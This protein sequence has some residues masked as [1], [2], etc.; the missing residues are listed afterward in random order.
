MD[1]RSTRAIS[2]LSRLRCLLT[3]LK[4]LKREEKL[5]PSLCF[6]P[7]TQRIVYS[8]PK[9]LNV[10]SVPV[11]ESG[12][13]KREF[14][15]HS[16]EVILTFVGVPNFSKSSVWL[17]LVDPVE[18]WVL[19]GDGD[20]V[21]N[22]RNPSTSENG[23]SDSWMKAIDQ[24]FG[25]D[26]LLKS[27][28]LEGN[29]VDMKRIQAVP[30][31]WT[32]ESD[33]E[34]T[35]FLCT[36]D[37]IHNIGGTSKLGEHFEKV[38][39]SSSQ[40]SCKNLIDNDETTYW[41]SNGS[42]GQHYIRLHIKSGIMLEQL[43][44]LVDLE[45]DSYLPRSV[46]VKGIDRTDKKHE[47][48]RKMFSEEDYLTGELK[49]LTTPLTIQYPKI[50]IYIKS[51]HSGGIDTRIHGLVSV[52]TSQGSIIDGLHE[53]I[54][55]EESLVHYPTLQS[56]KTQDLAIRSF[57]LH[58]LVTLLNDNLLFLLPQWEHSTFVRESIS[59]IKLLLPL[60]PNRQQII[61]NALFSTSCKLSGSAPTLSINRFSAAEH[62]E[63][64]SKDPTGRSTVFGQIYKG[65]QSKIQ[66]GKFHLRWAGRESQ[67][68][69]CKFSKEH[70]IDQGGGFRDSLTDVAEELCPPSPD[71]KMPLPFFIHS[72][73]QDQDSSN[74]Y[75][76]AYIPNPSC[77]EFQMYEF[78][79]MLMGG[80]YR[81]N[82][83]LVLALSKYFWKQLVGEPVTWDD[84]SSV[85][86]AEVKF[87]NSLESM[88]KDA[89]EAAFANILTYTT[90]LSSGDVVP[91]IS[92][93]DKQFVQYED[94]LRYCQLVR[95]KRMSESSKQLEAIMTGFAKCVPKEI[96]V[97]H[98]WREI[99]RKICGNPEVT[100]E[101]LKLH[102]IYESDLSATDARVTTMWRAL[103]KF[104]NDERGQFLRFITGRRRLPCSIFIQVQRQTNSLPRAA[105]C[106][107]SLYLPEYT[108]VDMAYN[109]LLYAAYSCIAIDTDG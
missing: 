28:K 99:E 92:G 75:R 18:G 90:L 27:A 13:K 108:S 10:Y 40:D 55:T 93:G 45:D 25:L 72:P 16:K 79:G 94:R 96:L 50:E 19:I 80:A 51:C 1:D 104:T 44:L 47:V 49:L 69:E 74:V 86:S 84:F 105:T 63:D 88:T 91:L 23:C 11:Q 39:A 58:R 12:K 61:S 36:C 20:S 66:N 65:L 8:G 31:G 29:E 7:K 5:H 26:T 100:V 106:S 107:N 95:A 54:F 82:E 56:V 70:I 87:I 37:A 35:K 32:Y 109:K 71:V 3:S 34:L 77:T 21:G 24:S 64:P 38:E 57:V 67:W 68:W 41:E 2:R 83:V 33:K 4:A 48:S 14:G 97:L 78:I 101:A 59:A 60:C 22:L 98:S 46:V 76:D 9:A 62:K 42:T 73:N 6:V 30:E 52:A 102:A 15:G 53:D 81:S 43:I 103:E 17:Q 89:F 85:D